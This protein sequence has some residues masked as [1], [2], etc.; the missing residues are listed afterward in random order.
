M[1]QPRGNGLAKLEF[2]KKSLAGNLEYEKLRFDIENASKLLIQ[3]TKHKNKQKSELK[4]YMEIREK[5]LLNRKKTTKID[6]S[7]IDLKLKVIKGSTKKKSKKQGTYYD[8]FDS[9]SESDNM[10]QAPILFTV[11]KHSQSIQNQDI[12]LVKTIPE[13]KI[14]YAVLNV[15]SNSLIKFINSIYS[16]V[17]F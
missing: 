8:I 11:K 12:E 9:T 17:Y 2:S 7:L 16:F 4:K 14:L 6:N 3:S 15:L 1:K 13:S 5:E 10:E